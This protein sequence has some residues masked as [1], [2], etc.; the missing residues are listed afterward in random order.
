[1]Q[2]SVIV[3]DWRRPDLTRRALASL[4]AQADRSAFE[5]VLVVNEADPQV[6]DEYRADF[7]DVVVVPRSD[8][9]G[10]AGGVQ[11]GLR[12]SSGD[13]VV[14]LNNDAVAAPGFVA[15]GLRHLAE[16]THVAAVCGRVE[17]EGRFVEAAGGDRTEHDLV[18]GTGRTWRR[19][20][21]GATLLNSTGVVVDRVANGVDRDWLAVD[22]RAAR[23]TEPFAFSGAAAFLRRAELE[24][25]GG[26]DASLFMYY[27]DVD[28]S[29]R[30]R[31]AG[32]AVGYCDEA[33]VVHRHAASSSSSGQLVRYQSMR[34]RAV[35]TARNGSAGLLA[36]V[37]VR[38]AA[39]L[40]RDALGEPYLDRPHRLRLVRELPGLV[41]RARAAGAAGRRGAVVPPAE[42]E[43]TWF[44]GP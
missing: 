20:P 35:V 16:E 42:L 10:F 17:L 24:S 32:H 21:R 1:V 43:A 14:L 18:D 40:V 44:T 34:N 28:V 31:L 12:R 30:L 37:L 9:A 7:P 41:V 39:R 22:G 38:T 2:A 4:D 8:N 11:A 5:V 33:R 13:V 3:V 36:R 23:T 26:F 27:E 25:V 6:V 19:S 15:A 29:W